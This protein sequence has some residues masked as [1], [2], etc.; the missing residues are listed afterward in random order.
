MNTHDN[1]RNATHSPIKLIV[2]FSQNSQLTILETSHM[3]GLFSEHIPMLFSPPQH[4][5]SFLSK[6]VAP[7]LLQEENNFLPCTKSSLTLTLRVTDPQLGK[8]IGKETL[9]ICEPSCL[10]IL[11]YCLKVRYVLDYPR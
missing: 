7:V 3:L 1:L 10:V 8:L 6:Y 9:L 11:Y 5:V 4:S 2:N